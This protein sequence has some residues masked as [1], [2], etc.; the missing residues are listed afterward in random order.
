MRFQYIEMIKLKQNEWPDMDSGPRYCAKWKE[1][2][3]MSR[4]PQVVLQQPKK[5]HRHK[6]SWKC[7]EDQPGLNMQARESRCH[8]GFRF[9]SN[10]LGIFCEK[11]YISATLQRIRRA[12]VS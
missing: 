6:D 8:R 12:C 11:Y 3:L 4:L 10:H 2:S 5:G 9:S 7:R 1:S